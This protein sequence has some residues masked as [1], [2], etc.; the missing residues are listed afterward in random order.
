MLAYSEAG[1]GKPVVLVHAFPL[2]SKMWEEQVRLVSR[3]ARVITPEIPGLGKSARQAEPSIPQTAAGV[4][5]ILDKLGIH[6]P[7]MIGGLS[8]GGYVMLEFLRQFPERV[9]GL[10]F[11]ATRANADSPEVK[12][13]R[14]KTIEKISREGL[15]AFVP[16][17]I[18]NLLGATTRANNP[19]LVKKVEGLILENT[20]EGVCEATRAMAGRRDSQDLLGAIRCPAIVI[21]GMED[22]FVTAQETEAMQKCIPGAELHLLEKKGHLVNLEAPE[23]FNGLLERFIRKL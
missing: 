10:G 18:Q 20:G 16:G 3:F 11:F 14:V 2:S 6:E 9:R 15:A 23:I 5:E 22:T 4:A 19:A 21:G 17:V 1:K 7:V 12:E 13:K 8:M